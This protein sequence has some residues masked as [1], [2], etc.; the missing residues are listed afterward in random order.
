VTP[1]EEERPEAARWKTWLGH[2]PRA[3]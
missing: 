3:P 1:P 2:E